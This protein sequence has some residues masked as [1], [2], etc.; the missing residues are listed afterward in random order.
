MYKTSDDRRFQKNK[1]E[2]RRAYIDL[3]LEKGYQKISISDIAEKADINRMTFYAHYNMVEDIFQ[4]FVDDMEL[5][6]TAAIAEETEFDM[7]HFFNLLNELM[8]QEIDFFRYAA[9]EGN[10]S[11]FRTA[12]RKTISKILKTDLSKNPN[13]NEQEQ[14]IASD[15]ASVC[16]AYSYL[17]WLAGD[18]GEMELND[19]IAVTK[20]MLKDQLEYVTYSRN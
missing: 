5:G 19:V 12:F 7:D 18:Y 20:K 17:D 9:K 6:I 13:Y 4:E 10:C 11:D 2:I 15:L 8:Y 1:K 14:I 3:I 16:I